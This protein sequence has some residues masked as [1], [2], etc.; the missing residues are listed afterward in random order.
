[1]SKHIHLSGLTSQGKF[2]K[3]LYKS[4][5]LWCGFNYL[6]GSVWTGNRRLGIVRQFIWNI[7]VQKCHY[8]CRPCSC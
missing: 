1:M 8:M 4:G 6:D 3:F 7:L 2:R 5:V